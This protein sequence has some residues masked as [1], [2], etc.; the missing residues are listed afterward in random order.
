MITF[1][2]I[3]AIITIILTITPIIIIIVMIV[4][5][6]IGNAMIQTCGCCLRGGLQFKLIQMVGH[7]LF[8]LLEVF[9]TC[10]LAIRTT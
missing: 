3:I 2:M 1:I 9:F 10:G 8:V 5:I 7:I 6:I 4:I